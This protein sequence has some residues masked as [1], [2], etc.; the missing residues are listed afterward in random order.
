MF[1]HQKASYGIWEKIVWLGGMQKQK[2][3]YRI[4]KKPVREA[5]QLEV[6]K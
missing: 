1:A 3:V 2:A 5:T 6:D 4:E